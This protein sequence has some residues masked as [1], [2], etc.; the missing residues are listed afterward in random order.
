MQHAI[1]NIPNWVMHQSRALKHTI[2]QL[3]NDIF[4]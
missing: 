2:I 1:K 3:R 4:L